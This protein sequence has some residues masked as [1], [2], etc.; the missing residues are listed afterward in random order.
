MHLEKLLVLLAE[1][2]F[3]VG[4]DIFKHYGLV[5]PNAHFRRVNLEV[6]LYDLPHLIVEETVGVL[7]PLD[8]LHDQALVLE[9]VVALVRKGLV[10]GELELLL[11][12]DF[13]R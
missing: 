4:A 12:R 11:V 10:V 6:R 8:A 9:L 2:L 1:L 13:A 5:V 7:L 3:D